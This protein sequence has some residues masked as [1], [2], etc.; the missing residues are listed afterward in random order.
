[1]ATIVRRGAMITLVLL[2]AFLIYLGTKTPRNDRNWA[3]NF[4]HVAAFDQTDE[5]TYRVSN[6][7]AF[8]YDA[9]G[10]LQKGWQD[11]K[12]RSDQIVEAWFFVEPFASDDRFGHTF[13]SFVFEDDLGQREAIAVSVEARKENGESYSALKG[14]FREYELSYVWSTEKDMTT[15]I[16]IGLDH[17]LYAYKINQNLD[18][19]RIIFDHFVK[20]TNALAVRPRFYNTIG[21]NC[22]N[23]LFKSVNDAIPGSIPRNL[24]WLMTG[25]SPNYLH[26]QGHLGDP[27][28]DFEQIKARAKIDHLVEQ[29]ADE[30]SLSFSQLWRLAY[31]NQ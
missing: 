19:A 26:K 29:H 4:Q 15:R 8:E 3:E 7:R 12:L 6:V 23:E 22:T 10:N 24:T 16:A 21:S 27:D 28:A 25:R 9:S 31:D 1:M 13:V 14:I 18:Q 5:S 30:P 17:P 11:R 2:S 20:R